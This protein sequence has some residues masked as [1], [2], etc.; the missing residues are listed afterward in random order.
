ML[1]EADDR[2][3]AAGL[4]LGQRR[5]LRVLGL[6]ERGVDRPAVR[7]ALG[8]A[9]L[10]LHPLD[11]VVGERLADV[12]GVDVRLG[13][14]VAHEV[15]QQPLDDAV[16]ADDLL[17]PLPPLLGEQRLLVLAAPDEPLLLEALEHLSRGRARDAEHLGDAC[18]ERGR[19][20]GLRAVLADRKGEEVDRLQ[21][22]VDRVARGHRRFEYSARRV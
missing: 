20:A 8:V 7:A 18:R 19:A 15:G 9:E 6:L 13:G 10:L 22:L 4:E 2:R 17:G 21:V 5:Q 16:L 12:V 1:G 3:P 14:G 11:H